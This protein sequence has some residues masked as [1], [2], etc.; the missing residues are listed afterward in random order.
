MYVSY[1]RNVWPNGHPSDMLIATINGT[2]GTQSI[3][4]GIAKFWAKFFWK[5]IQRFTRWAKMKYENLGEN[6]SR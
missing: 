5:I 1:G 2:I 4:Y 3:I 6:I